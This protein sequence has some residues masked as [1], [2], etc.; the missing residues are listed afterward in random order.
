MIGCQVGLQIIFS[1]KYDIL[2]FLELYEEV[3][4][5]NIFSFYPGPFTK[6]SRLVLKY[7]GSKEMHCRRGLLTF[8]NRSVAM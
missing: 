4:G 5:E 7:Q 1:G 3:W 2:S 8:N 6:I